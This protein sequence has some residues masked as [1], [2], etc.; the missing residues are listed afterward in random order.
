MYGWLA[1]L[2]ALAHGLVC[3]FVLI[4]A[5]AAVTGRLRR[6]R[7]WER[8]FYAVL[9]VVIAADFTP[10]GC[11][12]TSWENRLRALDRPGSGYR[13]SFIA[14]YLP[15]LPMR[16]YVPF[17]TTLVVSALL[18]FPFWRGWDRWRRARPRKNR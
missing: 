2:V 11:P 6:H 10:G 9:V 13:D 17:V 18:A 1:N 15:W 12:V 16:L 7:R 8:V 4:S 5:L 14:H 3:A